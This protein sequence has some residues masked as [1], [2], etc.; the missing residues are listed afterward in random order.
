MPQYWLMKSEPEDYGWDDLIAGRGNDTVIGSA[1]DDVIIGGLGDDNLSGG[2]GDD[3]F[4]V[5]PGDGFDTID[6]GS[7]YDQI[8]ATADGTNIGFLGSF[9]NGVEEISANGFA[10]VQISVGGCPGQTSVHAAHS[11]PCFIR[12]H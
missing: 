3:D 7:G 12:W 4:L 5:G 10:D 8:L 1:E 9:A 2:A 6:G 11:G